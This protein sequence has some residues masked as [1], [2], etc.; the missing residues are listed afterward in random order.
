[1]TRPFIRF[2]IALCV[3][4]LIQ[5]FAPPGRAQSQPAQK[6]PPLTGFPFTNE[7]LSYTVNW[8]SGL[9]LGE[10]HMTATS[11]LSGWH[12]ELSLDA[13]IPGF[14]VKDVFRATSSAAS[15]SSSFNK[16]SV[17][18]SK[19]TNETVTID[20][21]TATRHSNYG[22][23][24]GGTTTIAVPDCV[25]DA[26]TFLYFTR[27]E[28]GQGRVPPAQQIIFGG[29]YN[30]TLTYTGAETVKVGDKPV[31]TDKLICRVKGPASDIQF[32]AYFDRD[33]A[34]TPV[35]IRV[36]LIMGNFSLELVR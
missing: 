15:C 27:R 29:L 25:R 31:L 10:S 20:H 9:S 19:K 17:H 34:R 2:T 36:P 24:E 11:D 21:A 23:K 3:V 6:T 32:E 14:T 26:L 12:Y 22:G 28:L 5:P 1:M 30:I 16:D 4:S 33:P 8:P 7:T 35:A 18:G 13:G